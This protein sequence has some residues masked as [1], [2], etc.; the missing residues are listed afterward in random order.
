MKKIKLYTDYTDYKSHAHFEILNCQRIVLELRIW[1]AVYFPDLWKDLA[2]VKDLEHG[3]CSININFL[4]ACAS[5]CVFCMWVQALSE[6]IYACVHVDIERPEANVGCLSPLSSI[7][8]FGAG[9]LT[10]L[11]AQQL[12]K[13]NLPASSRGPLVLIPE[14]WL[15]GQV[16]TLAA[17]V[18]MLARQTLNPLRLLP[19]TGFF[20]AYAF[21]LWRSKVLSVLHF[22]GN[23]QLLLLQRQ[24]LTPQCKTHSGE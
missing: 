12:D 6:G 16:T 21:P 5:L 1:D 15:Q 24:D 18:L 3:R 9:S 14:L 22:A 19:S 7:L 23:S 13:I 17:Q 11:A 4:C 20:I 8:L 10:K 2:Y